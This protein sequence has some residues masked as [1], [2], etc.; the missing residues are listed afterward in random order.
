MSSNRPNPNDPEHLTYAALLPI[1][2]RILEP[3][4]FNY[5]AATTHGIHIMRDVVARAVPPRDR[6]EVMLWLDEL[7]ELGATGWTMWVR[8]FELWKASREKTRKVFRALT[9]ENVRLG[10]EVAELMGAGSGDAEMERED[11]EMRERVADIEQRV[12]HIE[13]HNERAHQHNAI[14]EQHNVGMTEH[15]A[16][17]EQQFADIRNYNADIEFLRTQVLAIGDCTDGL[18][19]VVKKQGETLI[20]IFKVLQ[21]HDAGIRSSMVSVDGEVKEGLRGGMGGRDED[22]EFV[23]EYGGYTNWDQIDSAGDG[24]G[25]A[26]AYNHDQDDCESQKVIYRLRSRIGELEAD[27]RQLTAETRVHARVE[28]REASQCS[29]ARNPPSAYEDVSDGEESTSDEE[30]HMGRSQKKATTSMLVEVDSEVGNRQLHSHVTY[31]SRALDENEYPPLPPQATRDTPPTREDSR[32]RHSDI[33]LIVTHELRQEE[34]RRVVER[35]SKIPLPAGFTIPSHDPSTPSI[36]FLGAA[37][38]YHF[39]YGASLNHLMRV[40]K[41]EDGYAGEGVYVVRVR[42]YVV[43]SELKNAIAQYWENLGRHGEWRYLYANW[44]GE[45]SGNT[46]IISKRDVIF[47]DCEDENV[48]EPG[49]RGECEC[50]DDSPHEIHETMQIRHPDDQ[51]AT[52]AFDRL[53]EDGIQKTVDAC[54]QSP[55]SKCTKAWMNVADVAQARN[56]F[57]ER[58]L[59]AYKEINYSLVQDVRWQVDMQTELEEQLKTVEEEKS[60]AVTELRALKARLA[61]VSELLT[62]LPNSPAPE[63]NEEQSESRYSGHFQSGIRGGHGSPNASPQEHC[64]RS[65]CEESTSI[66]AEQLESEVPSTHQSSATAFYFFPRVS[67][68]ALLSEPV[69]LFQWP[70]NTTLQ[71]IREILDYRHA[72]GTED[73]PFAN[74]VREIMESREEMGIRLPDPL[75]DEAVLIRTPGVANAVWCDDH[76]SIAA[77]ETF[78]SGIE[79]RLDIGQNHSDAEDERLCLSPSSSDDEDRYHDIGG[80][81]DAFDGRIRVGSERSSPTFCPCT[82]CTVD[83]T[84]ILFSTQNTYTPSL[85]SIRGGGYEEPFPPSPVSYDQENSN[86]IQEPKSEEGKD[87]EPE[88]NEDLPPP[89]QDPK[90]PPIPSRVQ[91]PLPRGLFSAME[92]E[93][94]EHFRK[95]LRRKATPKVPGL[96]HLPWNADGYDPITSIHNPWKALTLP[97]ASGN[98]LDRSCNFNYEYSTPPDGRFSILDES[99]ADTSVTPVGGLQL[100]HQQLRRA[101]WINTHL[102]SYV[103]PNSPTSPKLSQNLRPSDSPELPDSP[104][105][106]DA[107]KIFDV[108]KYIRREVQWPTAMRLHGAQNLGEPLAESSRHKWHHIKE[109]HHPKGKGCEEHA[110]YLDPRRTRC[111]FCFAPFEDGYIADSEMD[112]DEDIAHEDEASMPFTK[113]MRSAFETTDENDESIEH[114]KKHPFPV[115]EDSD[116]C[117]RGGAGQCDDE[118]WYEEWSHLVTRTHCSCRVCCSPFNRHC[119]PC[120][121][122]TPDFYNGA[123]FEREGAEPE[124]LAYAT[125]HVLAT[126]FQI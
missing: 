50:E 76:V 43:E 7:E 126:R 123:E 83:E 11:V 97:T 39:P 20:A 104:S 14:A 87:H 42:D 28:E 61:H 100:T 38:A 74:Q 19:E 77:W 3:D 48:D 99:A 84:D 52:E 34:E 16:D 69:R 46:Y 51:G 24:D 31:T 10:R 4:F 125:R 98:E 78:D 62:S 92:P 65:C 25:M 122:G 45:G 9:R 94:K 89:T 75:Q 85:G 109:W 26:G 21:L 71:Q 53:Y 106:P 41:R 12:A 15:L 88:E 37:T 8:E 64:H 120:T 27:L 82:V 6:P 2:P 73:D 86:I 68:I 72:H 95:A 121:L 79:Q 70:R 114:A 54:G 67:T 17:I 81:S 57:L 116:P 55:P 22:E 108:D 111:E 102:N 49:S 33:P 44:Q 90:L 63:M 13:R 107:H 110:A 59:E 105:I 36:T 29:D 103:P 18:E 30:P 60:A 124:Y 96:Q 91:S 115:I 80:L 35:Y 93:Q 23:Y 101:E 56:G 112:S 119:G 66:D 113:P 32:K 58:E 1:L 40:V 118:E 117:L 47:G 5:F